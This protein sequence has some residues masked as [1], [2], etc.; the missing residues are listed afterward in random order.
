ML[1]TKMFRSMT[2]GNAGI[3][4]VV[5]ATLAASSAF[6]QVGATGRKQDPPPS[7]MNPYT[8]PR[9]T[10]IN[11]ATDVKFDQKLDTQITLNN[12]FR[13]ESGAT[14]ELKKYFS[15]GKPVVL[16]MPFYKCP[17]I[18]SAMLDGVL[19][20]VAD[21]KNKFKIGR[22]YHVVTVSIAP[23]ETPE[24]A[25]AKKQ[26]YLSLLGVPGAETGWHFLTGDE[27]NIRKL[28]D[29]IG[30]KYKYDPKTDNYAHASGIVVATPDGHV[31][32]Y[33]Y[34]VEYPAGQMKL[35]LTEASQGKIGSV[36]DQVILYCYHY[37]PQTGTYGLA[38]FRVMQV[39]CFSTIF[40]LGLF[41]VPAIIKD[42]KAPKLMPTV[43]TSDV[44]K[45]D[46][47]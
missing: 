23:K 31:S 43:S 5:A 17:G 26:E 2:R 20:T 16:V 45:E 13:D 44:V 11:A 33:F 15:K 27:A 29:E 6:A 3:V 30:Y 18:C 47:A 42:A 1:V 7:L 28:A 46:K 36:V 39:A 14:V 10:G 37:D 22:D 24:L 38:I 40:L 9:S 25:N 32:R 21:P 35:A 8:P 34:G 19:K 41:I 4:A 12:T